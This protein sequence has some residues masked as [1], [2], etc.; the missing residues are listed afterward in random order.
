MR[1]GPAER[2]G[3]AAKFGTTAKFGIATELRLCTG[4]P[5]YLPASFVCRSNLELGL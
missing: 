5:L 1:F 3:M 4:C 2:F